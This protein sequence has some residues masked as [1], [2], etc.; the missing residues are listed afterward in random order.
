MEM[1]TP[2]NRCGDVF[3]LTDGVGHNNIVHCEPCGT[4]LN[5]IDELRDEIE[6]MDTQRENAPKGEKMQWVND[7]RESRKQLAE[8]ELQLD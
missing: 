5:S 7:L 8:L 2:C 6:Y 4:L 1:P 3:D